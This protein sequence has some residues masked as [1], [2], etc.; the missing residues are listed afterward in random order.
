MC[1]CVCVCVCV[2]FVLACKCRYLREINRKTN[3]SLEFSGVNVKII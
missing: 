3:I 2:C 1:V